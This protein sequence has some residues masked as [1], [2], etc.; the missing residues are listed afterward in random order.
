LGNGVG[1]VVNFSHAFFGLMMHLRSQQ[2]WRHKKLPAPNS[3]SLN[4]ASRKLHDAGTC[5]GNGFVKWQQLEK[6]SLQF[7]T[8]LTKQT[9]A[10]TP[11]LVGK[12]QGFQG[13]SV[14]FRLFNVALI[15]SHQN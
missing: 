15:S 6:Q 2:Q 1:N 14:S 10:D 5:I 11:T 4:P 3:E 8:S 9:A 12:F 7:L 13:I